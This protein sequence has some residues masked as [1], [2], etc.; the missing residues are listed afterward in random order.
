MPEPAPTPY[1]RCVEDIESAYEFQLAYAAQGREKEPTGPDGVAVRPFVARL[2]RGLGEIGAGAAEAAAELG[3]EAIAF[4]ER[5]AADAACARQAVD[6]ALSV[7][8]L[9]S[10]LI[11]NLNASVHLRTLLTDLFLFDEV[12]KAARRG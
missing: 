7:S 8:N 11:D 12:L 4:V 6:L 2:S 5:I 1:A 9:S 10:Q 3:P